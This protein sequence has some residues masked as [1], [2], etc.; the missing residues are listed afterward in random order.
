M[1]V[2]GCRWLWWVG[3]GGGG[4]GGG[5]A[6]AVALALQ[7]IILWV[8]FE[9]FNNAMDG[10]DDPHRSEDYAKSNG[11]THTENPVNV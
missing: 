7:I 9:G 4:G 10:I 2:V 1:C 3:V 8:R 11:Q 5:W 6:P